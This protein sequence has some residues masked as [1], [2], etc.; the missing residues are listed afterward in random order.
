MKSINESLESIAESLRML[1]LGRDIGR[2]SSEAERRE[3]L[4]AHS[5]YTAKALGLKVCVTCNGDGED[6][7][8]KACGG[9]GT[10]DTKE[11]SR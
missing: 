11:P 10:I 9:H 4:R 8:C 7:S 5:H 1:V 6:G 2:D 3:Y